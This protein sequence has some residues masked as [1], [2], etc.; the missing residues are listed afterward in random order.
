M[1]KLGRTLVAAAAVAGLIAAAVGGPA[2][3]RQQ[4]NPLKGEGRNMKIVANVAYAGGTDM[5]FATIKG[6]DYAFTGAA[7]GVGG[8]KTGGLHVINVD[9]PEKPKEVAFLNCALYQADIQISFDKKYVYMAADSAGGPDSCQAVGKEGF[10]II[11][12]RNPLKP[13][14]VGFA[15]TGSS[16]NVTAHP[17][18][19]Y[20][21]NSNS[22]L[23]PGGSSVIQIWNV[24]NPAKPEM[25]GTFPSLPHAPHDISFNSDGTRIVTAAISQIAIYNTED[26]EAPSLV[27]TGQCPGCSITHDAKFTPKDDGLIVGDEGGGGL[28]YPCP[29]GALYFYKFVAPDVPALTGVYEPEEIL[30]ARDGQT[31]PGAC[32]SHVFDISDDGKKVAI[33]W[34]SA[35]TRVLDVSAMQGAALGQ[36]AAPGGV[37]EI[38]YFMPD[39]GVSWSSKFFKGE[40]YV[41]SNDTVR[42]FD[43]FKMES[44]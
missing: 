32:T 40:K 1:R 7:P 37:V 6:H 18:L 28:A 2:S 39:G 22:A 38:G 29:G 36:N 4:S 14:S 20:V 31:A 11:D 35:G 17:K 42:G 13:K 25:V 26:V 41:F 43:V 8:A 9:N 19:P 3:A 5:E 10:L 33:S 27:W 16:H 21:Y 12:V 34:Y 23:A 44:K 15:E 24:K 30:L